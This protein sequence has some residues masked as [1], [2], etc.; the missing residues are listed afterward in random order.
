[1]KGKYAGDRST[2]EMQGEEEGKIP[3]RREQGKSAQ[4]FTGIQRNV[5]KRRGSLREKTV[6]NPSK[7][8]KIQN[9]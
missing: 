9:N 7:T 8:A 6:Q 4:E 2:G 3:R 5:I 1:M